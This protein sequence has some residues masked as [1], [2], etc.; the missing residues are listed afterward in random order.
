MLNLTK[1]RCITLRLLFNILFILIFSSVTVFAIECDTDYAFQ[2]TY[3][4]RCILNENLEI[5]GQDIYESPD[6]TNVRMTGNYPVVIRTSQR[7]NDDDGTY[8]E[9]NEIDVHKIHGSI[10]EEGVLYGTSLETTNIGDIPISKG[11]TFYYYPLEERLKF[12][13]S[14]D[15]INYEFYGHVISLKEDGLL[16]VYLEEGIFQFSGSDFSI[17]GVLVKGY[18]S[19]TYDM[20][21]NEFIFS[22]GGI[23]DNNGLE[24]IVLDEFR[25]KYLDFASYDPSDFLNEF[26]QGDFYLGGN[27][28]M[29]N[30]N[31]AYGEISPFILNG[32]NIDLAFSSETTLLDFSDREDY[33]IGSLTQGS[34]YFEEQGTSH[35]YGNAQIQ[36][37]P[38]QVYFYATGRSEIEL[39]R[40]ENTRGYNT[41]YDVVPMTISFRNEEDYIDDVKFAD[42][43]E[44]RTVD[45]VSIQATGFS[46]SEDLY[47]N[48][49]ESTA[50]LEPEISEALRYDESFE[51]LEGK[52]PEINCNGLSYDDCLF[53]SS[54]WGCFWNSGIC[55]ECGLILCEMYGFSDQCARDPCGFND[56][57]SYCSFENGVCQDKERTN[58]FVY[59]NDIIE[60]A[61]L[62]RAANVHYSQA[63]WNMEEP[64]T[65]GLDCSG[66]VQKPWHVN[67]APMP[68]RASTGAM[69]TNEEGF[70]EVNMEQYFDNINCQNLQPADI[71]IYRPL[72]GITR[73]GHAV[74]VKEGYGNKGAVIIHSKGGVGVTEDFLIDVG[75]VYNHIGLELRDCWRY[76]NVV[77]EN[78]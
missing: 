32:E 19:A 47:A 60:I 44:T 41:G 52:E 67:G 10:D 26:Y 76:K 78:S 53:S 49:V 64:E 9:I 22:S 17:D 69:V 62:Y 74:M 77:Y 45:S 48:L 58:S 34:F 36:N 75:N 31:I 40:R 27:Y 12:I 73:D 56:L 13:F 25:L 30:K 33:V 61:E 23:F 59:A 1:E 43:D 21:E 54:G 14:E 63:N 29:L 55:M 51:P 35:I 37:G 18:N 15:F 42:S 3:V 20:F 71:L 70:T 38:Y 28:L 5:F 57:V 4:T 66:L 65:N 24:F 8:I 7:L 72:P 46:V 16:E 39:V 68:T 6:Q 2:N 11:L 50:N